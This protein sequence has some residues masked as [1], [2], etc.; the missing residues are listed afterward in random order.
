MEA[1]YVSSKPR[2]WSY[3]KKTGLLL[4]P[5]VFYERLFSF[6]SDRS[7]II[8]AISFKLNKKRGKDLWKFDKSLLSND[9]YINK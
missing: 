1:L 4:I 6:C 5:N 2:F 3:S 8:F 9:E 7:P